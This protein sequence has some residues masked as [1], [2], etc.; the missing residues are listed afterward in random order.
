MLSILAVLTLLQASP[1]QQA[2][3]PTPAPTPTPAQPCAG[4]EFDAFDFWVGEW[5]VFATGSDTKVG[6]SVITR[7][8]GGCAIDEAW[9]P[10]NGAGGTS[11]TLLNHRTQRWEQVWIGADGR[12]VD[13]TGG[14][15]GESMVLTGYWDDLAGP[16]QDVLIR[17]VWRP[18]ADGS[19]QQKG[20]AS[21]DHGSAWQPFFDFTYRRKAS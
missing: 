12:R 5:D 11:L 3:T 14:P 13:F 19:V 2:T 8:S 17:I 9:K 20:E 4:A 15:T 21:G 16:G 6:E 7:V 10:V 1:E 18:N